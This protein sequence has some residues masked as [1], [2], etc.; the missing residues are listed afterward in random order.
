MFITIEERAEMYA[1]EDTNGY[2]FEEGFQET[3]TRVK[4]AFRAGARAAQFWISVDEEVPQ[5]YTHTIQYFVKLKNGKCDVRKVR[6]EL[7][8]CVF[9]GDVLFWRPVE[10]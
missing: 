7:G 6:E 2:L 1:V 9:D 5:D 4:R 10:Q 8:K 3:V